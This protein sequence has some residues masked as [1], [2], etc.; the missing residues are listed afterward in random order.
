MRTATVIIDEFN[1]DKRYWF[2]FCIAVPIS[3]VEPKIKTVYFGGEVEYEKDDVEDVFLS[4]RMRRIASYC[5]KLLGLNPSDYIIPVTVHGSWKSKLHQGILF[6]K[7]Y[8]IIHTVVG[9]YHS[10]RER[11]DWDLIKKYVLVLNDRDE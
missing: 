4:A 11:P 1:Y 6:V 9:K 3:Y 7:K 2:T 10:Y 5:L 8:T